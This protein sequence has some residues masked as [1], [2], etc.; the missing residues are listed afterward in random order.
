[1]ARFYA[2]RN[3][4][5]G[6]LKE[7]S[8]QMKRSFALFVMLASGL[9]VSATAQTPAT[10]APPAASAAAPAARVAVPAKI[11]VIN[12]QLAVG[13]TNE[14][15]RD[16]ADLQ[17]KYAP[18][19]AGLKS[20]SDEVDSLTKQLQTEGATMPEAQ[21]AS[22]AKTLDEKT[23]QRD[24]EVEDARNDFQADMQETYNSLA[25]KVYD[26]MQSYADQQGFTLVLDV[27]PQQSPVLYAS[28][29]TVITKPV[30][31][32]YNLKSGIPA[33]PQPAAAAPATPTPRPTV[34]KST[35][36]H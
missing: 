10:T 33:Q 20:L 36:T 24:R 15:L 14:G 25:A 5:A 31:D 4:P 35:T 22:K 17:R 28:S 6:I 9:C 19:E 32:A 26:V 27:S 8:S 21:R 18:R 13:Q 16:F 3:G 34:P 2:P 30:I 12:F 7:F 1:M 29:S 23:K 11:A